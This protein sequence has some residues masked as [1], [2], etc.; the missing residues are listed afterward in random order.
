MAVIF[1][2][3]K[4]HAQYNKV[5][6]DSLQRH[7]E[8]LTA[9]SEGN[10]S[11]VKKFITIGINIDH[12]DAEGATALFYAI[13]ADNPEVVKTLLYYGANPNIATYNGFTPLMNAASYSYEMAYLLLLKPQTKLNTFD[14]EH[15]TALHYAAYYGQYTIV[16]MLLFYGANASLK[17]QNK[18]NVITLAA[19]SGDTAIVQ[20]LL[21]AGNNAFKKNSDDISAFDISVQNNDSLL[22]YFLL[23]VEASEKYIKK[24]YNNL[25]AL[26]IKNKNDIA[27]SELLSKQSYVPDGNKLNEAY[28]T[29]YLYGNKE[30]INN[31]QDKGFK[32][33][34]GPIP[35]SLIFSFSTSFNNSDYSSYFGLGLSEVRYGLSLSALYGTRFKYKAFLEPI[36]DNVFYQQWERRNQFALQLRKDFNIF[37][38]DALNIIP[39]FS[40]ETQWHW[41]NYRGWN[42]KLKGELY[43]V[44]E[45]GLAFKY[46][47]FSLNIA[48]Q[49][50]NYG[51]YEI[52]SHKLKLGFKYYILF[53]N[54][55]QKYYPEWMQ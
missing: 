41:V 36:D 28:K 11:M 18:T 6:S 51:L 14:S 40:I 7:F 19:Y 15:S 35:N 26:A 24:N 16:D 1:I 43:I 55:T 21:S 29:A 3:K 8:F 37:N 45:L 13:G 52:P 27:L 10:L 34:Y 42:K 32:K 23:N 53:N 20:L 17:S 33:P 47:N 4:N 25:I 31:L 39:Y 54:K 30:A 5:E 49:Y 22:F 9:A 2:P 38:S 48:Y 46:Q 44:P 12:R 50:T